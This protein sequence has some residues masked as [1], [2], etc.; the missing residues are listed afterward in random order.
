MTESSKS[1]LLSNGIRILSKKIPHVRS[2]S[3]GM[4]VNVGARDESDLEN[5]ISHFIEHMLF[6]GTKKRTG[7]QIAKEFDAIGGHTNAFTSMENTC[8]HARVMDSRMNVMVDI[9]S[10]IFL[11]S[12]FDE[13]E[14]EKERPVIFQEICMME[15]NPEEYIHTLSSNCYWGDNALGRSVLGTRE[16]VTR[17]DSKTIKTIFS[18]YYQPD[19]IVVSAAGNLDHDRLI[20]LV[21]PAFESLKPGNQ[22]PKRITPPGYSRIDLNYKELEQVHICINTTGIGITDPRRYALSL[23][24]TILGGNMSSRLFQEIR[25]KRGLAYSVYSYLSSFEDTGMFGAYVG[26]DPDNSLTAVGLILKEMQSLKN[27]RVGSAELND[28]KEYT[29]GSLLLASES[30]DNQM[31]R[32]AQNEIHFGKEIP[33]EEILDRIDAVS[34][35][36]ILNLTESLFT[37]S[38]LSLTLLGQIDNK[39]PFEDILTL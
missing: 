35:N 23:M 33:I 7:Y 12:V 36:D 1:T 18:N 6:K 13:A 2:V 8:Y 39:A 15:D 16:N 37:S 3:M 21:G 9:L 24:N 26:T 22:F 27:K 32:L 30:I 25:E 14:I 11:N 5:G 4:W 17:F 10:D 34:E 20:D 38:Q 28:A 29:K 31:V 19:R